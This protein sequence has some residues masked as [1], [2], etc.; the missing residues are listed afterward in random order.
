MRLE[1]QE[2]ER[3][4]CERDQHGHDDADGV[5][6]G[7][8]IAEGRDQWLGLGVEDTRCLPQCDRA[9]LADEGITLEIEAG[10]ALRLGRGEH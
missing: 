4:A 3:S 2:G 1:A 10:Q 8:G 9:G 5:V 6:T 7:K